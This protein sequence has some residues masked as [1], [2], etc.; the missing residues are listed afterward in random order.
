MFWANL[1]PCSLQF[2]CMGIGR[3]AGAPLGLQVRKNLTM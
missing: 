2:T 1:T 3:I